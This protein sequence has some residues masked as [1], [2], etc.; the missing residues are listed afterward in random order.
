M[1]DAY[2]LDNAS[3]SE[4]LRAQSEVWEP[5]GRALLERLGPGEGRRAVD[6]GCGPLGWLR[7]LDR[8][9]WQVTGTDVAVNLLDAARSLAL[10]VELVEDDVFA[11]MLPER[12]FDLVHAR[13]MI[14]PLGRAEE[15]LAAYERLLAPGGMLVLEE[16]D[17]ASWRVLPEAPAVAELIQRIVTCFRERG[18][19]FDAG[20]RLH[21]LLGE[22]ELAAHVVALKPD[23][24]YLRLPLQFAR[25]LG[26]DGT[27]AAEAELAENGRWGF[28]FM[29]V[30]AWRRF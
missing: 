11:S 20:R 8:A 10:P 17:S 7:I 12:S 22:C 23:H 6:L 1:P 18:G 25:S 26:L 5:A 21:G 3:E 19:D 15:L 14:A 30:Q 27:E 13:F 29:V 4:R 24:P 28:S 9:G 2:L 16:T